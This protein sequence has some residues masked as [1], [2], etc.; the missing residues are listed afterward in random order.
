V[1]YTTEF[2]GTRKGYNGKSEPV[3]TAKGDALRVTHR[4]SED[5]GK[6]LATVKGT[7]ADYTLKGDELYVRARVTSSKPK[8]DSNEA[9]EFERAWTQ[10]VVR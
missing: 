6:V 2:I 1:T 8:T 10:P 5:V 7:R 4:Y 3:R 9:P